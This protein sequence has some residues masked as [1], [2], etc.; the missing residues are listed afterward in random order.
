MNA[1]PDYDSII[2][3]QPG[4]TNEHRD[5]NT[6]KEVAQPQLLQENKENNNT[7]TEFGNCICGLVCCPIWCLGLVPC[8]CMNKC[9]GCNVE[10]NCGCLKFHVYG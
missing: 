7:L 3:D 9:C 2:K 6:V 1:P 5:T 10:W 4:Q 8:Y